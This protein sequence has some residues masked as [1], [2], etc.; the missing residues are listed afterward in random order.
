[1]HALIRGDASGLYKL[2]ARVLNRLT[3]RQIQGDYKRLKQMLE[4]QAA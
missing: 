3:Q 1:V 4:A 2:A